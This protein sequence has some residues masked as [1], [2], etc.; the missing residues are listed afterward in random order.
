[1]KL[2]S[3]PEN[4]FLCIFIIASSPGVHTFFA[5]GEKT[6]SYLRVKLHK[7]HFRGQGQSVKHM[8]VRMG[9]STFKVTLLAR[10][11]S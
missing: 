6:G 7:M 9:I 2:N 10:S 5:S 11:C 8:H 1:M 3:I 4:D